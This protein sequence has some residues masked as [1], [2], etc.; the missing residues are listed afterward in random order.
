MDFMLY[1]IRDNR[2]LVPLRCAPIARTE[3]TRRARGSRRVRRSLANAA[4]GKR[5]PQLPCPPPQR[6]VQRNRLG[7]QHRRTPCSSLAANQDGKRENLV[8]SCAAAARPI[9]RR[10]A[11]PHLLAFGEEVVVIARSND[12]ME[13]A[14]ACR[15]VDL[16]L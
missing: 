11:A 15:P 8:A 7:G 16:Q 14:Q 13:L 3:S 6:G 12:E 1:F 2:P 9:A 4:R 5:K 10:P